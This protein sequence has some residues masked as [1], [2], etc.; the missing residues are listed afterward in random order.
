MAA[1]AGS[2][3]ARWLGR[4]QVPHG[5]LRPLVGPFAPP[6]VRVSAPAELLD[7]ASHGLPEGAPKPEAVAVRLRR[8]GVVLESGPPCVVPDLPALVRLSRARGA[9]SVELVRADPSLLTEMQI[10]A[11]FN[12]YWRR[13]VLRRALCRLR[14]PRSGRWAPPPLVHAAAD[15]AFWAGVR[16]VA[17]SQEWDRFVKSSYVVLY[18]HRIAGARIPGHG[19]LD[20]HPRRF[21]RQLR[22]LHL[23]GLRQLSPDEL[24]AFHS[25][26]NATIAGRRYVLAADDGIADTV[27]AFRR[28]G[29]L[30]PQVFVCTALVGAKSWWSDGAPLARWE[31]LRALDALG[32]HIGSHSR[33]HAPLTELAPHVLAAELG[34][35]LRDL[36]EQL[37]RFTRLLAYPYGIHDEGVRAAAI[38]AGYRGAFTTEPGRNGAGTDVYCLRRIELKDWDGAFVLLWT[39]LTGEP[40]PWLWER[41]RRRLKGARAT[42]RDARTPRGNAAS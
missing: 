17:T 24:L 35:A 26:P 19:H 34:E 15:A 37:P 41:V 32:G 13:R 20:V 12:A 5:D 27:A 11:S 31:E 25:D 10:G 14:L 1:P 2:A 4:T 8:A 33:S 16:S 7:D 30:H 6:V 18:Y 21:E 22:V 9:S 40:L 28:H 3:L 42:R 38:E 36:E 39:T 29:H 23:L